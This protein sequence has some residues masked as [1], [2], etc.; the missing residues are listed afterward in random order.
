MCG[1]A[2]RP[3]A[4]LTYVETAGRVTILHTETPPS[5][6][7]GV[8]AARGAGGR[9]F[10]AAAR[11]SCRPAGSRGRIPRRPNGPT[12]W[13]RTSVADKQ[14]RAI[15]MWSGPRNLSTALMRSFGNRSDCAVSDEPF[16]AAYLT[17]SGVDH[18]MREEVLAS[19]PTDW[20]AVAE[21]VAG[22]R[23]GRGRAVVPEA[24]DASYAACDRARLDA[25]L[26]PRLPHP[27]SGAGARLLRRQ[28][29]G[30]RA[31]RYRL[32]SSRRSC[33]TRRRRSP[34]DAPPVIDA[35]ALLA[36]PRGVLTAL[37]AA[38]AIPFSEQML[39]WPA[40][41]RADRRGV[42]GALVRRG[43]QVDRIRPAA[44]HARARRAASVAAGG[45]GAAALRAARRLR[46]RLKTAAGPSR[47]PGPGRPRAPASLPRA[48][49][50]ASARSRAPLA[51]S[52]CWPSSSM[53]ACRLARRWRAARAKVE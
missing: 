34:G 36:D 8:A 16:Y 10:R 53:E 44:A 49:L 47:L 3:E 38:L 37:C 51:V 48:R 40:G 7:D 21:A 42:G 23:A 1:A 25:R 6:A 52:S 32:S 2:R 50:R 31:R 28:A 5:I 4:E 24:H 46:A 22:P 26:P 19:Q 17:L 43:D 29:A 20:R 18:P 33:S 41:P 12:S 27:P 14:T 15:A 11:R 9:D 35:D 45:G 30:G 39:R 13:P